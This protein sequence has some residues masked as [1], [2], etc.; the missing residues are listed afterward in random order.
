MNKNEQERFVYDTKNYLT[1]N[2]NHA[3]KR[4][5]ACTSLNQARYKSTN[6]DHIRENSMQF[7]SIYTFINSSTQ[8]TT[9][10]PV[11]SV[12]SQTHN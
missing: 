9:H 4:V 2:T 1:T 11:D 7:A 10:G 5:F 3:L 12:V 6:D 8:T